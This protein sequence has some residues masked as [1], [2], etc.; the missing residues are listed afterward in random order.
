MDKKFYKFYKKNIDERLSILREE[1]YLNDSDLPSLDRQAANSMVENYLFNYELPMG[2]ALNFIIDGKDYLVPMATEEPSVIAAASNGAKTLGNITTTIE[3]KSVIGQIILYEINDLEYALKQIETHK[4]EILDRA[5]QMSQSMVKRGGGPRKVWVDSFRE[6]KDIFISLYL[7]VDTC[8]AMGANTIN[9]ILE[10]LSTYIEEITDSK[11]LMRIISNYASESIV[12]AYCKIDVRKLHDDLLEARRIAKRI[13]LASLYTKLDPYRAATHNKGIMNGVDAVVLATGNDFRAI[14]AS[15][16]SYASRNGKY[17]GLTS[18]KFNEDDDT[19]SG[20]IEIP[21]PVATLGG[22]ISSHPIAKWSLS[23]LG[24]PSA[25]HLAGI[26]AAVGLSQNF[27]A[28]RAIVTVGIQ[29]GHMSLHA[30]S[31]AKRAGARDE[32]VDDLIELLKKADKINIENANLL[33]ERL[34]SSH[35]KIE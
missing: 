25:R 6:D 31:V 16:H 18:W 34:R 4:E 17:Q 1:G 23:L 21:M 27:S 11:F 28:I 8:D 7:S 20:S 14:E 30:R 10:G 29:E 26:I 24:N 13:D 2:L 15:A 3:E 5:R 22:T 33:L 35:D 32:E 12:R 9:T 19:L